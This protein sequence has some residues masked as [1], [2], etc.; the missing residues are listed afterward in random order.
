MKKN[1]LVF[2][3]LFTLNCFAQQ[4]QFSINW[5]NDKVLQTDFGKLIVPAFDTEHFNYNDERGLT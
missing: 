1:F 2:I 5:T 3:L 4:K